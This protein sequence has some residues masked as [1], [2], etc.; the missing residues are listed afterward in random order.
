MVAENTYRMGYEAVGL[1]S[2]SLRGR[3]LPPLSVI[4]PLVIRKQNLT[5]PEAVLSDRS[6]QSSQ[7]RHALPGHAPAKR[8][9][10]RKVIRAGVALVILV[11]CIIGARQVYGASRPDYGLPYSAR[12]V[13]G[14]KELWTG[15]GGAWEFVEG[16][17]R[18]DANDRGAK[19]LAGFPGW[20][21]YTVEAD[22]QL[23]GSGSVGLLARVSEAE[24]G[25]NSHKGYWAGVRNGDNSFVLGV[26]NFDYHEA[27]KV[28]MPDPVRPFRWY[29]VKMT[30]EGC[31]ITASAS[32][33]GMGQVRTAAVI[34]PDCFAPA[35]LASG[36]TEPA[37]FSAISG[38]SLS[39][40]KNPPEIALSNTVVRVAHSPSHKRG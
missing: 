20:K 6:S 39:T 8:R 15:L 24:V 4:A 37:A 33:P 32:A 28:V 31:Q 14:E 17:L 3:P 9:A 23:L 21:D 22:V 30:V 34:Y 7:M 38:C 13:S 35:T 29:H 19:I 1:I 27:T 36:Q 18:N 5:S 2:A 12:F 26:F 16:S 40:R 10:R 25:E 11:V